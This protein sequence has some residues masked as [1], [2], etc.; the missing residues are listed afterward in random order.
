MEESAPG[1]HQLWLEEGRDPQSRMTMAAATRMSC[2]HPWLG[3]A[4]TTLENQLLAKGSHR[5]PTKS[6]PRGC[7]SGSAPWCLPRGLL[8][9]ASGCTSDQDV[10]EYP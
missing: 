6:P 10:H 4:P 9:T 1:L 5:V 8:L 2:L 3:P 7:F